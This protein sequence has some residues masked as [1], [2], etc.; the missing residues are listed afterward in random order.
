MSGEYRCGIGRHRG[1]TGEE[2]CRAFR[3]GEVEDNADGED[4]SEPQY[5][6]DKIEEAEDEAHFSTGGPHTTALL[7][8]VRDGGP[9]ED[10][11]AVLLEACISE[12]GISI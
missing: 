3:D 10:G 7:M 12:L 4:K 5:V 6:H 11:M 1:P 8:A 9:D 2:L